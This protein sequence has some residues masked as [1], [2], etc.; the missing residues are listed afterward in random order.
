MFSE[1]PSG[2]GFV[3]RNPGAGGVHAVKAAAVPR[4][5]TAPQGVR[6]SRLAFWRIFVSMVTSI[7]AI[8]IPV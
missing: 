2:Y 5:V 3:R 7:L 8:V 6:M 4:P 1:Y